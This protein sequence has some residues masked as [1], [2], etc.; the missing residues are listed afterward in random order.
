[1]RPDSSH[2]SLKSC[3]RY[4]SNVVETR[5][6]L[7]ARC[8]LP[9]SSIGRALHCARAS[10]INVLAS[11]ARRHRNHNQPII[12]AIQSQWATHPAAAT[13]ASQPCF[14]RYSKSVSARLKSLKLLL[15]HESA[16]RAARDQR[17]ARGLGFGSESHPGPPF[18]VRVAG[19][20]PK[21]PR[22]NRYLGYAALTSP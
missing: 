4:L 16:S 10:S 14:N 1:S 5:L 8:E 6:L 20:H 21:V 11:R 9:H 19:S 22:G 3:P 7:T 12:A 13:I 18:T 17:E 15:A 2:L